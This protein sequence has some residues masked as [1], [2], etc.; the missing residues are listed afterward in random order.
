[1]SSLGEEERMRFLSSLGFH[2]LP[3]GA[4][5]GIPAAPKITTRTISTVASW[6]LQKQKLRRS[7]G[8]KMLIR[9]PL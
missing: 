9:G 5:V 8:F 6:I 4:A 7:L 2:W 3:G 1:M